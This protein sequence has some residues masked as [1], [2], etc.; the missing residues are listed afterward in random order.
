M[1]INKNLILK[2]EDGEAILF[3]KDT[4]LTIWLNE[5]GIIIWKDIRKGL[6]EK[7]I[8]EHLK[9]IYIDVSEKDI[10]NDV[11]MFMNNL[12]SALKIKNDDN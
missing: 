8:F 3:D 2:E 12:K 5:T 4:L 6:T 7:Q 9:K 11:K 1:K 10:K